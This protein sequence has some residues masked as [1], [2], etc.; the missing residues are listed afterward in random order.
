MFGTFTLS[1]L[2]FLSVSGKFP[3]PTPVLASLC[4]T[5][6]VYTIGSI[7]GAHLNPA[8]TIGLLFIKKIKFSEAV[9]Y[10]IF[11]IIGAYLAIYILSQ[12]SVNIVAPVLAGGSREF[13]A[14]MLGMVVFTF[15]ISS[16]VY[17][18]APGVIVGGSLLLGI[19]ISA[20]VGSAG[21]LNPAVALVLQAFYPTYIFGEIFGSLIGFSFYQWLNKSSLRKIR[22][23]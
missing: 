16:V 10:I 3:I 5:M 20:L 18:N 12:L 22:K 23:D 6:F 9:K 7:S 15:G 11:Q 2:V 13:F 21:I 8:V 4:L 1:F 14:E 17:G 19:S